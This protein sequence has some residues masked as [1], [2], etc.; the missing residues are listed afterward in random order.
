MAG[1]YH[2]RWQAITI[3]RT[4]RVQALRTEVVAVAG[5]RAFVGRE[6]GDEEGR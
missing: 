2:Y 1:I 6:R 5:V 3:F 4:L